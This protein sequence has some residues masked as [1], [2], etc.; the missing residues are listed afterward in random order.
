MPPLHH[1]HHAALHQVGGRQVLDALAAQLD[2]ALGHSA[3]F[4]AQQVGHS[5]QRGRLAGAIAAQNGHDLALG[6]IQGHAL[7]HQDDVVVND[8]DAV[9]VENYLGSVHK[10]LPFAS[11]QRC[12]QRCR[13]A[14]QPGRRARVDRTLIRTGSPPGCAVSVS[15]Q[16][17]IWQPLT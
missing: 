9:D 3:A 6:H 16:R 4:A 7:E 10:S 11:R 1:L 15:S 14:C 13:L 5:A 2:R 8:L 17:R 12:T